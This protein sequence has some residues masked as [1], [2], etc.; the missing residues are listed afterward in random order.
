MSARRS[1]H[2]VS[3]CFA[4]SYPLTE[5]GAR[6]GR[7]Y[8]TS[9]GLAAVLQAPPSC[10]RVHPALPYYDGARRVGRYPALI[11]RYQNPGGHLVAVHATYLRQDGCAK[12]DVPSP[13]KILHAIEPGAT[14]GGAI[15]L[16]PPTNVLGIAEGI[17]SAL[18]LQVIHRMPVWAA[19]CADNLERVRVPQSLREL[20]IAIDVDES[21]RGAK[22]A[23]ALGARI[24]QWQP[25]TK[26]FLVTPFGNGPRDMND[27]LRAKG[28][29]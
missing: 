2:V 28:G 8:L 4:R 19:Y 9:R 6:A 13:K 15:R 7:A 1:S 23:R 14:K 18:S 25:Q 20:Y 24:R 22:A 5:R 26:C 17:E 12:A 27:E 10:L 29:S 11:A 21:G 16:F 3:R